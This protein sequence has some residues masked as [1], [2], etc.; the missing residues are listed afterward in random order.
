[1]S[2]FFGTTLFSL[3]HL[4]YA[5]NEFARLMQHFSAFKAIDKNCSTFPTM[6]TFSWIFV[7]TLKMLIL[8]TVNQSKCYIW[9]LTLYLLLFRFLV[10]LVFLC[11]RKLGV[12]TRQ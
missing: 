7:L 10:S 9:L 2:I 12:L 8:A 5:I 3:S 11:G 1:M 4:R 6:K